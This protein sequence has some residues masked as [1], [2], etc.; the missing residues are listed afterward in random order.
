MRLT[1]AEAKMIRA[2]RI[3]R[4]DCLLC[5]QK[6]DDPSF[7]T[8]GACRERSRRRAPGERLRAISV[9]KAKKRLGLCSENGCD[10]EAVPGLRVCGYHAELRAE[11]SKL[12]RQKLREAGLCYVCGKPPVPG[13]RA[14]ASCGAKDRA[15]VKR[16]VETKKAGAIRLPMAAEVQR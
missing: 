11:R 14:C 3:K 2:E 10:A 9:R 7:K 15:R 12:R 6:R 8:C 1:K 5:G 4:G 16:H 13:R